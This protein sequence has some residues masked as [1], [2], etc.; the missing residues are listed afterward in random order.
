M[1]AD[2]ELNAALGR[3]ARIALDY[4][5]LD[6]NGAVH[7]VDDTPELDSRAPSPVRSQLLMC[8]WLKPRSRNIVRVDH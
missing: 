6:F 8:D 5:S 2:P 3:Q 4:R 7:R 1:S